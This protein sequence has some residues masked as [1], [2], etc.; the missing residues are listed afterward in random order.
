MPFD[1]PNN[2][3]IGQIVNFPSS[4]QQYVWNG[5]S[6]SGAPLDAQFVTG[7]GGTSISSSYSETA[8]FALT[9]SYISGAQGNA[10]T[11]SYALTASY[12]LTSSVTSASYSETASFAITAS[13]SI[14]NFITSSVTSSVSAS[15]S[16]TAS[17]AY[18][19]NTSLTASYFLTSS[20]T[21]AS[22]AQTA[23][24]ASFAENVTPYIVTA[25]SNATYTMPG[26]FTND[27]C[28]Y[29]VVDI[30][31]NVPVGWFNMTTYRFTPQKA[32]Y[33]RI[34]A[35]YDVYRGSNIEG[36]LSITKN[37][38]VQSGVGGFGTVAAVT[39]RIIYLNGTTDYVAAINSG[40]AASLRNQ[41]RERSY[42]EAEFI[43]A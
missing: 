3:S 33:W 37:G 9:A 30:L 19:A 38:V 25:Y 20:V 5:N 35:A 23:R 17:L 14:F 12:F 43:S 18:K 21:S 6:W 31:L 26:G 40:G 27:P 1:F 24:S 39:S 15:Y 36:A 4:S 28:R 10:D 41:Y 13:Y 8:S 29:N 2:P 11:A 16:D 22:F 42:F 34:T 32:G 7:S